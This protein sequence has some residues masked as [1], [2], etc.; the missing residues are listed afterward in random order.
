MPGMRARRF[1]GRYCA[2]RSH[3]ALRH[4]PRRSY[5]RYVLAIIP[6]L[7]IW[8]S[9]PAMAGNVRLAQ[10]QV[11]ATCMDEVRSCRYQIGGGVATRV[12]IP[13]L[14]EPM[15][16]FRHGFANPAGHQRRSGDPT[17]PDRHP[18]E[19][20]ADSVPPELHVATTILLGDMP[21]GASCGDRGSVVSS[22]DAATRPPAPPRPRPSCV[23]RPRRAPRGGGRRRGR[24]GVRLPPARSRATA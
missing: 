10:S 21:L 11:S 20:S 7:A 23:V 14:C 17:E 8:P 2:G 16:G 6:V 9:G 15:P 13:D 5:V 4:R 22:P 18:P 1:D 24:S 3:R 19:H 12:R